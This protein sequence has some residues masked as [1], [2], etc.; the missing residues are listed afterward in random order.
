LLQAAIE[1]S[2]ALAASA[3]TWKCSS[4]ILQKYLPSTCIGA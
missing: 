2:L 4:T 1:Q 3:V